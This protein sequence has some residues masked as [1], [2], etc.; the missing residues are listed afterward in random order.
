[1]R[2]WPLEQ[3]GKGCCDH[4]RVTCYRPSIPANGC[5]RSIADVVRDLTVS[6]ESEVRVHLPEK[7][8]LA[9]ISP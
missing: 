8:P 6:S 4:L 2:Q 7:R 5:N 1:M 9:A 3:L